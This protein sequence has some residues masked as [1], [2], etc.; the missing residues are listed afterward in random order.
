MKIQSSLFLQCLISVAALCAGGCNMVGFAAA[1]V[2]GQW[3]P[4]AYV[5]AKDQPMVVI[6]EGRSAG[7]MM[8]VDSDQL[9]RYVSDE[10]S[11]YEIA[12][13]ID[14]A[15]VMDLRSKNPAAFEKM[16]ISEIG[17]LVGAKQVLHV[18][19][20]ESAVQATVDEVMRGKAEARVKVVDVATA[21]LR[22]PSD[23]SQGQPVNAKT[24]AVDARDGATPSS[25]RQALH[26]ELAIQIVR[27]F[28][29]WEAMEVTD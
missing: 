2:V 13:M 24:E 22:F 21:D 10:L 5:P 17:K 23:S 1:R 18:M 26:R 29:K 11:R 7:A 28:R 3:T 25:V 6:A 8:T 12:P 19:L 16:R 9:A 27:L 4:A 20:V 14:P 15:A